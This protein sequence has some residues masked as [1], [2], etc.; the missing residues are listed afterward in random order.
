MMRFLFAGLVASLMF[1]APVLA[2]SHTEILPP[3]SAYAQA[4]KTPPAQIPAPCAKVVAD[5][6]KSKVAMDDAGSLLFHGELMGQH[7]VQ[8]DLVKGVTLVQRA[9]DT[10][11]YNA[12]V[13]ILRQR[14]AAGNLLTSTA[15]QKLNLKP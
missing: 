14:A 15:L 2:K 11:Q 10:T 1:P 12:F 3:S 5:R 8:V 13:Q 6:G 4:A 7:C 9:R